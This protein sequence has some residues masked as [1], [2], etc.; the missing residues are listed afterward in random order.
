M[1][2]SRQKITTKKDN[3]RPS[4]MLRRKGPKGI[5]MAGCRRRRRNDLWKNVSGQLDFETKL[6]SHALGL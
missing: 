1:R 5:E 2:Q 4:A 6:C 3:G